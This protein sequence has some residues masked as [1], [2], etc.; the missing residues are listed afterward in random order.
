MQVIPVNKISLYQFDATGSLAVASITTILR[1]V[2]KAESRGSLFT[3]ISFPVMIPVLWISIQLTSDSLEGGAPPELR[4]LLFLLAFSG[5][6]ISVSYLAF[7][8]IWT[9]Q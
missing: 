2:A 8:F 6:I 5:V 9:E 7:K 1:D 3:V 4:S